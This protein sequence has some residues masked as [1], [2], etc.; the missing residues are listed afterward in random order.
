LP[1]FGNDRLL[2]PVSFFFSSFFFFLFTQ[3]V[4][5]MSN[6]LWRKKVAEPE[7]QL[8]ERD[9]RVLDIYTRR[10]KKFDEMI[11][12]CCCWVGYDVLLGKC[13]YNL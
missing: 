12:I 9:A 4:K 3:Q 13:G 5:R 6:I 8:S 1:F 2:V 7:I 10:M 11:K